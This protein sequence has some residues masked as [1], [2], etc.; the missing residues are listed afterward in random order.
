MPTTSSDS[1]RLRPARGDARRILQDAEVG[2]DRALDV[3]P[4]HLDGHGRAVVQRGAM[5][6][7]GR[8]RCE[9]LGLEG[10]VQLF[11]RRAQ[12]L[13]DAL[14]HLVAG[15]RRDGVLQLGELGRHVDR[16]HRRL[17]RHDLADLDVG[18]PELLEHEPDL[19]CGARLLP[20]LGQAPDPGLHR[21]A[22]PA[23]VRRPLE[24]RVVAV[25]EERVVDLLQPQ[26]LAE[27]VERRP[28]HDRSSPGRSASGRVVCGDVRGDA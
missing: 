21:M 10:G 26:V 18:G 16:Q 25:A 24:D 22:E 8:G 28:P 17:A 4:L 1:H 6:L 2:A 12:L 5:H 27:L 13:D 23:D 3:R 15:E 11:R 7:G 19:D 14:A 20:A 9:R